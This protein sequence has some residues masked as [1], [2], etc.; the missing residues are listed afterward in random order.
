MF[1]DWDFGLISVVT[2]FKDL[3]ITFAIGMA[4]IL[5]FMYVSP[6]LQESIF[7]GILRNSIAIAAALIVHPYIY[8][9]L[10]TINDLS[11]VSLM[12]IVIKEVGIGMLLAMFL[13]MVVWGIESAS[14]FTDFQ[15]GSSVADAYS[16]FDAEPTS[17]TAVFFVHAYITYFFLIGGF[18]LVLGMIYDSYQLWPPLSGYPVL[19]HE[20]LYYVFQ[21]LDK[22]MEMTMVIFG[23]A[24]IIMFLV[25]LTMAMY[26]RYSPQLNVFSLSMPVKSAMMFFV[27]LVMVPFI[28]EYFKS[29]IDLYRENFEILR[30]V[31]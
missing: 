3:M 30:S 17:P 23:P 20:S 13:G 11:Y 18:L 14:F 9:Q 4:R 26:T 29:S 25:E 22:V 7:V 27:L 12:L 16:P 15:R 31:F 2:E 24:I 10:D 6:F 21:I 28:F 1:Q 8:A 19:T 5:G